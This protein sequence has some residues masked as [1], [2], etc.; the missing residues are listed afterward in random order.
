MPV[1]AE[2]VLVGTVARPHGLGGWVIVNPQTDFVEERF[3]RGER[4]WAGGGPEPAELVIEDARVQKGRPVVKFAGLETIEAVQRLAGRELRVEP[5]ALR[6]L[7]AGDYYHHDLVGCVVETA[8]GEVVG[9]VTA[10]EGAGA[11]CRLVVKGPRG[12]VQVPF[13]EEICGLVDT[14]ARRIRIDPPEGLLDLNLR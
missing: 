6:A 4:L 11:L 5:E 10:V 3:A 14:A 2:M 7:D 12:D 9:T 13:V 1:W 8:G